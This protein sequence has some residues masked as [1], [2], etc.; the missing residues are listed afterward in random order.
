MEADGAC[1][2]AMALAAR[3]AFLTFGEALE[4][5]ATRVGFESLEAYVREKYPAGAEALAKRRAETR[6][7]R[8]RSLSEVNE[9]AASLKTVSRA[10]RALIDDVVVGGD[11][12]V[13]RDG[14]RRGDD[15]TRDAGERGRG[16]GGGI[17]TLDADAGL[18]RSSRWSTCVNRSGF[19][20]N[21]TI[22]SRKSSSQ[23]PTSTSTRWTGFAMLS[24]RR[25]IE[26][27]ESHG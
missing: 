24:P 25:R 27:V 7:I 26:L 16:I 15:G 18:D 4:A 14:E 9:D 19:C 3:D 2:L 12:S 11:G 13:P 8:G 21:W 5:H 6:T 20:G 23:T 22:E 17:G 1:A 10:E